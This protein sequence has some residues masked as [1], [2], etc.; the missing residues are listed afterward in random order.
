MAKER[1]PPELN[2]SKDVSAI[3]LLSDFSAKVWADTATIWAH[4]VHVAQVRH[5][6][7]FAL[8]LNDLAL[9]QAQLTLVHLAGC[10]K[11]NSSM[12]LLVRHRTI[13]PLCRHI[14]H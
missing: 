8:A 10:D 6:L 13:S 5:E 1:L 14:L 7:A 3:W 2:D 4:V 9:L 12:T 11:G